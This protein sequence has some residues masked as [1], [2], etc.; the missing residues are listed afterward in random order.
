MIRVSVYGK[1]N[2]VE[3]IKGQSKKTDSWVLRLDHSNLTKDALRIRS[4]IKSFDDLTKLLEIYSP[5]RTIPGI[6]KTSGYTLFAQNSRA[7]VQNLLSDP[8]IFEKF[9]ESSTLN[10]SGEKRRE[11]INAAL[12]I[13]QLYEPQIAQNL[14]QR[15][16]QIQSASL[17][18]A[19]LRVL[20]QETGKNATVKAVVAET[21]THLTAKTPD[22]AT[23]AE[24]DAMLAAWIEDRILTHE[25]TSEGAYL[26][27]ARAHMEFVEN[28]SASDV[29]GLLPETQTAIDTASFWFEALSEELLAENVA[30]A[31]GLIEASGSSYQEID[32]I[33]ETGL[34]L[35]DEFLKYGFEDEANELLELAK[36]RIKEAIDTGLD[37]YKD[38]M[39]VENMTLERVAFYKEEADLFYALSEDYPGFSAYVEAIEEGVK[40]G[41]LQACAVVANTV[42]TPANRQAVTVVGGQSLPLKSLACALYSNGHLLKDVSIE[43]GG[44]DGSITLLEN[45]L[46]EVVFEI[47]STGDEKSFWG[48]ADAWDE[49]MGA[50]IIPPPTGKPDRN[51]V[52]ECDVLAGD[53]HDK[54]LSTG[55]VVLEE[56]EFDY[57][58]DRAAE[59]CIAA[60][61][62]DP[63]STRQVYQLARVL[64]FMGDAESAAHY[65]E[66]A[67]ERK[68]APAIHLQAFSILTYR[69]DEDAF[70]DAV[71]L[72]KVSSSLGYG[73][74]KT[75]LNKLMP[76]GVELFRERPPPSDNEI[77]DAV[78]RKRCESNV[79]AE[80]CSIRTGVAKKSCFQTSENVFSCELVLYHKCSMRTGMDGDPLMQM[81]TGLVT[82]SCSPTTDPMFMKI[83]KN[84]NKWTARKEF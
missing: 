58:F 35:H 63:A 56:V 23:I 21:H 24:V 72:L 26:D 55:G 30:E 27:S 74:S 13:V 82:N 6:N 59:A 38:Q 36:S 49:E 28:V 70:F 29:D 83:T 75:E 40:L 31:T 17:R 43:R 67:A 79:F 2:S 54:S 77:L 33:L 18:A 80:A 42:E 61:E 4:R 22:T 5:Y 3:V 68:Y 66:V 14:S 10:D 25:Q 1:V 32:L 34:A 44:R 69:D 46:D 20:E 8:N 39:H 19:A 60:V 41:Q 76:P 65:A 62:Y 7:A 52:T 81:F 84:G 51:G 64:E 12:S 53:P 45:N 50:L 73:P 37:V 11:R 71:D 48:E 16:S 47:T 78:G 15:V 9:V 57:D